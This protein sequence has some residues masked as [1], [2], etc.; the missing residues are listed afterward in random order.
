MTFLSISL[1]DTPGLVPSMNVLLLGPGV[2]ISI[3]QRKQGYFVERLKWSFRK[4]N[5]RYG[6]LIQ[7]Y[8][9]SLSRI[10][11]DILILTSNSDFQTD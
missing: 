10:L 11:N 9:V 2:L 4:F 3:K 7:Q 8:A 6:D 5:G 1:Y